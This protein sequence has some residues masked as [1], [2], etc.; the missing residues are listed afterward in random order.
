MTHYVIKT[1]P[2][3]SNRRARQVVFI[4]PSFQACETWFQEN[5][6]TYDNNGY[7]HPQSGE[8]A[9]IYPVPD[10]IAQPLKAHIGQ[11]VTVRV[12]IP[13]IKIAG[14]LT[15]NPETFRYGL[16][17]VQGDFTVEVSFD[18]TEVISVGRS[19]E[20]EQR[21]TTILLGEQRQWF[22]GPGGTY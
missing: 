18:A 13:D 16:A 14:P 22:C 5:G 6:Y 1:Q 11:R 8:Q 15:Y 2:T 10:T 12:E 21:T 20:S 9:H 4:G 3:G 7:Q 17:C 19:A